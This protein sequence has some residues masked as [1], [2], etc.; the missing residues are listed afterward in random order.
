MNSINEIFKTKFFKD[1][2]TINQKFTFDQI[3]EAAKEG[4]DHMEYGSLSEKYA[5]KIYFSFC[6]LILSIQSLEEITAFFSIPKIPQYYIKNGISEIQYYKY[7]LENHYIKVTSILDYTAKFVNEV[8]RLGFPE[9]NCNIYSIKENLNI[10]NTNLGLILKNF[11]SSLTSIKVSRNNIIHKGVHNSEEIKAIEDEIFSIDF[12]K[13]DKILLDYFSTRKVA[14]IK[15]IIKKIEQNNKIV[16][17]YILELF[18]NLLV[19]FHDNYNYL[20]QFVD[21][22][23]K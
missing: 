11:E 8:Y 6:E 23:T 4:K 14:E 15:K 5:K 22:E 21:K 17:K 7:H 16:S 20:L 9:K 12:I 3:W 1:L 13:I 18:E 2:F 19:P 10:K